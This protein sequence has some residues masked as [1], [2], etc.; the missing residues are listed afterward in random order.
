MQDA[1]LSLV[2][3]REGQK[4]DYRVTPVMKAE[5]IQQFAV[6]V[7]TG[8]PTSGSSI[9]SQLQQRCQITIPART[10]R[11]HLGRLGL[12]RIKHSL[13]ELVGSIK[14]PPRVVP[15][16]DQHSAMARASIQ[17]VRQSHVATDKS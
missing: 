2:D 7:I 5:L 14:K 15:Q 8:E 16:N 1:A 17:W 9:S 12:S 3:K 10:V 11:H 13:P 6:D 4:Q